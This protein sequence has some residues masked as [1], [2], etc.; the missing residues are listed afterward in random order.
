MTEHRKSSQMT[1]K[2]ALMQAK[3]YSKR[4]FGID[5]PLLVLMGEDYKPV[6]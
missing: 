3:D 5:F 4:V 2:I 6:R 1:F